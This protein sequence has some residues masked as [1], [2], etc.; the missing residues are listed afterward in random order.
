MKQKIAIFDLDE[1]LTKKGTWGR[2]VLASIKHKP[3]KWVP[4]F[5]SSLFSQ[6]KYML[7]KG[8]REHV[9]ESMMRW[10]LSGRSHTELAKMAE[11]FA[12]N[13]VDNGLRRQ[14]RSVLENHRNAGDRIIIATAAVDLIIEPIARRLDVD[15]VV[16][17]KMAYDAHDNLARKLGGKNCYGIGKLEMV[18]DYLE[19]DHSFH[20]DH[21]H[22]TM[23]SDS[24]SDLDILRWADVGIAVNPSP[25]L[26]KC[27]PEY[28]F[29]IQDWD[30]QNGDKK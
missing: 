18:R 30:E 8:P 7:G 16:C 28:G 15:E 12:A 1:T 2:F 14:A 24:R 13:E 22:I 11:E 3:H 10:T 27:A 21:A 19:A 4:F 29:V 5:A 9:K 6:A 17:T 26:Q 25:R 23:Y 20:R